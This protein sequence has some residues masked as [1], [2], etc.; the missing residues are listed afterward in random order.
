MHKEAARLLT[1]V[2]ETEASL[3]TTA[4]ASYNYCLMQFTYLACT[5]GSYAHRGSPTLD[6]A[7]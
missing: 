2:L 6:A 5:A 4:V 1:Q 7:G 3:Q